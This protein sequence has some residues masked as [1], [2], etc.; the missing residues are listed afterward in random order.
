M[1][2]FLVRGFKN[3]QL[4]EATVEA[5]NDSAAYEKAVWTLGFSM[6]E[7]IYVEKVS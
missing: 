5:K 4:A 2:K 6:K 7:D 3:G 1:K